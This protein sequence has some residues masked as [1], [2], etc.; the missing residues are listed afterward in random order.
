MPVP[1]N[2]LSL[3]P[4]RADAPPALHSV[5]SNPSVAEDSYLMQ[6]DDDA[7]VI[8]AVLVESIDSLFPSG[9]H[10]DD[11]TAANDP[12]AE[13]VLDYVLDPRVQFVG[14]MSA[15][16]RARRRQRLVP[17]RAVLHSTHRTM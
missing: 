16:P 2:T 4:K 11:N 5:S 15:P 6:F 10:E 14:Q 17:S 8:R 13:P 1:T 9:G 7:C 12:M 3:L